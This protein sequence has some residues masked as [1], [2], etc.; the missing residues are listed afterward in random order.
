MGLAIGEALGLSV[1][2]LKPATISQCFG[3]MDDYK[4]VR[5]YLG[6]GVKHYHMKGLYGAMTQRA[7]VVSDCL[8]QLK[9]T[10]GD[11]IL[12]SMRTLAQGGPEGNFG[13]F[14]HSHH[15]FN[16]ALTDSINRSHL[17]DSG[18]M[19]CDLSYATLAVPIALY[20]RQFKRNQL[21]DYLETGLLWTHHPL[22]AI[23]LLLTGYVT[24]Q[25]LQLDPQK[26]IAVSESERILTELI[27]T[28]ELAEQWFERNAYG[29]WK[30]TESNEKNV[31]SRTLKVLTSRL[32]NNLPD[33]D[34]WICE[35]ASAFY[36][37]E[38]R[39][40][41]QKYVLTLFPFA[42]SLL[43]KPGNT[44]SGL[45]AQATGLGREADKSG[46]IL[47][48][49]MGAIVG[50]SKIPPG[51]KSGLVN[52]KEMKLR[53]ECLYSRKNSGALKNLVEMESGLTRKE[54][55]EKKKWESKIPKKTSA[56]KVPKKISGQTFLEETVDLKKEDPYQWRKL[57]KEKTKSKRDRRK[58]GFKEPPPP[59]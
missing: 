10:D 17:L 2:G 54:F 7:L 22:E 23:G 44:F 37:T 48:A 32:K 59:L 43:L 49:W 28:C 33:I 19:S 55:E 4:D 9:K 27:E 20:C 40:P 12:E 46:A 34:G 21:T 56:N 8:L 35:N 50:A 6:K 16:Q 42:L 1:R 47:G 30:E 13:L 51:L 52:F 45:L 5:P 41:V 14:R 58:K 29:M 24:T 11:H 57:Q 36:N 3:K 15:D 25:C 18:R 38:I 39:Y 31:F 26:G 53:A